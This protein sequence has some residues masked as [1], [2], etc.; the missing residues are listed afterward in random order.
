MFLPSLLA[1]RTCRV[2]YPTSSSH[3]M[4][5]LMW[6]WPWWFWWWRNW[7]WESNVCVVIELFSLEVTPKST[8][9]LPFK[10]AS[11]LWGSRQLLQAPTLRLYW[12]SPSATGQSTE[13]V[14]VLVSVRLGQLAPPYIGAART[15]LVRCCRPAL[16]VLLQLDHEVKSET[17]QSWGQ[18]MRQACSTGGFWEKNSHILMLTVLRLEVRTQWILRLWMPCCAVMHS[19][20]LIL[21]SLEK[22]G[23]RT[24]APQSEISHSKRSWCQSQTLKHCL[25]L[26]GFSTCWQCELWV[27]QPSMWTHHIVLVWTPPEPHTSPIHWPHEPTKKKTQSTFSLK[28]CALGRWKRR[29]QWFKLQVSG[30]L[31]SCPIQGHSLN[32]NDCFIHELK[33]EHKVIK[34]VANINTKI[35][36]QFLNHKDL[37][38]WIN[39]LDYHRY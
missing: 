2:W 28:M 22:K 7:W 1:Q 36:G 25:L 37:I 23:T 4:G 9:V 18:G 39:M 8:V 13:L 19:V 6:A 12:Y 29:E 31:Q 26:S 35:Q 10:T 3:D 17:T 11:L 5:Y 20:V 16:Q 14:Q 34:P 30:G 33:K 15:C 32:L 21:S 38:Y 27:V 24:Q